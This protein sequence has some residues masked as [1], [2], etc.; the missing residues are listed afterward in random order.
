MPD[1]AQDIIRR[2]YRQAVASLPPLTRDIFLA[3]LVD[4][5]DIATLAVRHSLPAEDVVERLA[6]ALM[7]ID[8]ALRAV[9]Y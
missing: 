2:A 6:D 8:Q 4:G 1:D 5:E 3:H 7:A 9:G